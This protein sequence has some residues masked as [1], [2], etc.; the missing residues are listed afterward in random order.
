MRLDTVDAMASTL[1][2]ILQLTG[3]P[4]AYNELYRTYD[5]LTPEDLRDAARKYFRNENRTVV[6]LIAE[7]NPA[8]KG[9][10]R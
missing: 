10:K 3:E 5:S 8:S 2:H 4:G 6:T 1:A 9:G 7:K